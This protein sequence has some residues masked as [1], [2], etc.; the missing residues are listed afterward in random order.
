VRRTLFLG[1]GCLMQAC[2][3]APASPGSAPS[4][5]PNGTLSGAFVPQVI[6]KPASSVVDPSN[7]EFA[8]D[9]SVRSGC[10]LQFVR[11]MGGKLYL[12][13]L[14]GASRDAARQCVERLS[15]L[16]SVEFA[17]ID[18]RQTVR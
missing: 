6:V 1:L 7:T 3:Q 15:K 8:R 12:F 16:S 17:E 14:P 10:E 5:L 9:L 13:R 11:E 4:S 2:A 18:A